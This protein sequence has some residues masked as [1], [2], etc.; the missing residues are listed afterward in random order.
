MI[1]RHVSAEEIAR[2]GE[3][4]VSRRK[5]ARISSHLAGCS[6]CARVRDDLA[7]VPAL[8]ARTA[9]PPMP[10]HLAARIQTAL[11]TESARR[12]SPEASP[13]VRPA[14]GAAAGAA[15]AAGRRNERG[16][17]KRARDAPVRNGTPRAGPGPASPACPDR[18][19]DGP[20]RQQQ[21][22]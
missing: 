4:D 12:A 6:R 14:R 18:P 10:D 2:F 7:M 11:M 5:A 22:C 16:R 8:L 9:A 19:P 20:P 21:P 13:D 3:G 1:K 17:R 15:A